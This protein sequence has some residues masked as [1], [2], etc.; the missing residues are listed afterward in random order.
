M[1]LISFEFRSPYFFEKGMEYLEHNPD[2]LNYYHG[3]SPFQIILENVVNGTT[4]YA[5]HF[6]QIEFVVSK[7][8]IPIVLTDRPLMLSDK[9]EF[10][11]IP[12]GTDIVLS[13]KRARG[14]STIDYQEISKELANELNDVLIDQARNWI[15]STDLDKLKN[16]VV[17]NTPDDQIMFQEIKNLI[18]GYEF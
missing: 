9:D 2:K 3:K 1:G 5:N 18:S 16:I 17:E 10:S 8:P 14:T 7:S 15:V 12:I 11:I 13:F 6:P 4:E